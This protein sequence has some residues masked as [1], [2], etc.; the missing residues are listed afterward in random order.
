M[1]PIL[2]IDNL[3]KSFR[4]IV[5]LDRVSF[6]LDPGE[7]TVLLGPSGSGKSTLFRSIMGLVVPESG[8]IE[9]AGQSLS[10]LS[11][12]ARRELLQDVGLIFQQFNLIDRSSALHNVLMGRLGHASTLRVLLGMFSQG[13]RQRSLVALE[14]VGML[15]HAYARASN[16]SGGQQQRVAIA[17]VLSQGSKLVLADE[18][19]A[20]LD[21]RTAQDVL[22]T[23]R[24]TTRKRNMAVLCSLHQLN[25]ATHFADRIIALRKGRLVLDIKRGS[26]SNHDFDAIYRDAA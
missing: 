25:Y 3:C 6:S 16:L 21:P 26:F 22:S 2:R 13:D 18:P 7:L 12:H 10:G 4:N 15:E 11:R 8:A 1:E 5:A 20:S 19:V 17:R 24:E 14:A 23:L 9:V